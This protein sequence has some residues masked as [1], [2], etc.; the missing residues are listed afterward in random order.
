MESVH[1]KHENVAE[2]LLVTLRDGSDN[3]SDLFVNFSTITCKKLNPTLRKVAI[4]GL[5]FGFKITAYI[6]GIGHN[7]Q[8]HSIVLV[9]RGRVKHLP[10]VRYHTVQGML[11]TIIVNDHQQ[12]HSH[13]LC[14]LVIFHVFHKFGNE[15]NRPIVL[16][17]RRSF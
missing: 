11:D 9:R 1:L 8:E 4:V 10:S 5:T 14:T 15:H 7:F 17:E 13:A 2:L 3:K 6:P 16:V 12:G